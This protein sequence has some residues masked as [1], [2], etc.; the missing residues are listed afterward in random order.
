MIRLL[1]QEASRTGRSDFPLSEVVRAYWNK[2]DDGDI[3]IDLIALNEEDE[4]IRFGSSKRSAAAHSG[5]A[6]TK[7]NTHIDRFLNSGEGKRYKHF[8]IQRALYS[9]SFA[10]Q[11]SNLQSKG[12]ICLDLTD[13]ARVLRG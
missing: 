5:A 8:R 1:T 7:F 10:E 6:L 4:S 12:Y 11:R 3:E 2:A 9:P 13:F